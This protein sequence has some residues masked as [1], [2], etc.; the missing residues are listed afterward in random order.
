M[1]DS[2]RCFVV[3]VP[4]ATILGGPDIYVNYG[5][6]INLTCTIRHSP[7]PPAY[8]FWYY[9]KDDDNN[10]STKAPLQVNRSLNSDVN[11]FPLNRSI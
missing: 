5:S 4:T 3:S 1:R 2:N 8:I 10:T 11:L 7:E 6:T 9:G